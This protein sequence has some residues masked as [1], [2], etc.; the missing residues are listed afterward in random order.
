MFTCHSVL[1]I[2]QIKYITLD[3]VMDYGRHAVFYVVKEMY[4]SSPHPET[5]QYRLLSG[6][7]NATIVFCHC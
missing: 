1:N 2:V 3:T 5:L 7:P 4:S 6:I